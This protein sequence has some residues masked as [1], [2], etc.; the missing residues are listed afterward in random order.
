MEPDAILSQLRDLSDNA[1]RAARSP[2][3]CSD[4]HCAHRHRAEALAST[5]GAL[6][7]SLTGGGLI[8]TV[9]AGGPDFPAQRVKY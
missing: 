2:I 8:P 7:A 1:T 3:G 5:F 9:W 6:D 4:A